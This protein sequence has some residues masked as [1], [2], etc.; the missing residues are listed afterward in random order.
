MAATKIQT[1][2]IA[3]KAVTGSEDRQGRGE[4]RQDRRRQ[5]EG[6]GP[7]P[8]VV[9]RDQAY[10]RV[11][12]SGGN[13]TARRRGGRDHRRRLRRARRDLLRPR[14]RAGLGH[15][16][17]GRRGRLPAGAT[18]EVVV[19]PTAGCAAPFT[20]AVTL[21]KAS[22]SGTNPATDK[23]VYVEFIR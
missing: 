6:Q 17:R 22:T 10:G 21:T 9:S 5:G 12:K 7:R 15:G 3:K 16:E 14:V 2:D 8:G 20:D 19:N 11:N 23:D 18:V 1:N 4:E 13:V